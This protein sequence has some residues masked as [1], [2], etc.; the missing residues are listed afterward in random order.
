MPAV[1]S[2]FAN[3]IIRVKCVQWE[4]LAYSYLLRHTNCSLVEKGRATQTWMEIWSELLHL[5]L[6]Q[7]TRCLEEFRLVVM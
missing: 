3:M 4:S 1:S 5:A 2:M 6:L 7:M